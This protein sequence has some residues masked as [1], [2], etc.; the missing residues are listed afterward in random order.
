MPAMTA[1]PKQGAGGL[2]WLEELLPDDPRVQV[3]PMFGHR[4]AFVGGNMF[5]GTFGDDVILRLG[6]ADRAELMRE[7]GA[8]VFEPMAGR[9]MREYVVL[10]AAW[11]REPARARQWVARSLAFVAAL[12]PKLAKGK[13][14]AAKAKPTRRGPRKGRTA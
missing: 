8:R 12:P 1:F 13:A 5:L 10:P 11:R 9:P 2:A 3:K 7:P 4:A 14:K 6:E